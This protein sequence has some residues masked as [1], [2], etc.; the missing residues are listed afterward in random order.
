[1]IKNLKIKP[2]VTEKTSIQ[3]EL[4]KYVFYVSK[5]INKID[6]KKYIETTFSTKVI[7]VNSLK[8]KGKNV[9]RGKVTGKKQDRKKIIVTLDPKSNQE[10][11]KEIF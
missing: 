1:M 4:G 9:R 2:V 7:C 10:K 11:I 5:D 6:M 3:M 8:V